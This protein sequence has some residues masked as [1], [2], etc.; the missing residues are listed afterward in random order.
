MNDEQKRIAIAEACGYRL[1]P[2]NNHSQLTW[3][4]HGFTIEALPDYLS[5]LN[6]MHEAELELNRRAKWPQYIEV[7][8]NDVLIWGKL[9]ME[10][11]AGNWDVHIDYIRA[12]AAQ[13]AEAF[14]LTLG[15]WQP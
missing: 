15:L 5:D 6:A 2:S 1:L 11:V 3:Q 14:G 4:M 9:T 12:T 10:Q 8:H 7:L 13:R